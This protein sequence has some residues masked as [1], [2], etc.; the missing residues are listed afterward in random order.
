MVNNMKLNYYE[1]KQF[2]DVIKKMGGFIPIN[3]VTQ[4]HK[5]RDSE[6]I[7]N[8]IF[9]YDTET[10]TLFWYEDL[11]KWDI[12]KYELD[13][14]N[15]KYDSEI[16]KWVYKNVSREKLN[17]L[18]DYSEL[19]AHTIVYLWT[20]S[21][22][23]EKWD[24]SFYGRTNE[25]FKEFI[26]ILQNQLSI[27]EK[28]DVKMI[29]YVHNLGFDFANSLTNIFD[30][31][32]V[33]S[34]KSHS[35]MYA[36]DTS[37]LFE[38]RDSYILTNSS[39]A[40]LTKDNIKYKKQKE[41]DD[42]LKLRLPHTD[43]SS[44]NVLEYAILDTLSLAES[45]YKEL[46]EYK[47]VD[48]IP[49]TST[50][51]L[52][53]A[54]KKEL[55]G[56]SSTNRDRICIPNFEMYMYQLD[57]FCGGDT[58]AN[59]LY[60]GEDLTNIDSYDKRSSYPSVMIYEKYPNAPFIKDYPYMVEKYLNNENYCFLATVTFNKIK[61]KCCIPYIKTYKAYNIKNAHFDN[62]RIFE[63]DELTM[64]LTNID[65]Q[66]I[67]ENYSIKSYVCTELYVTSC[68]YLTYKERKFI[69][70]N[71]ANKTKLKGIE[72]RKEDYSRSKNYINA[73]FG[74]N[75]TK[76]VE[77]H[78][79][80]ANNEWVATPP[81]KEEIIEELEKKRK[82]PQYTMYARGIF[83]T[84]YARKELYSGIN[85]FGN[86][87][88]VY[89]DTDSCKGILTKEIEEKF[90]KLNEEIIEKARR[91]LPEDLFE[92]CQPKDTKGNV[93]FLGTWDKET[94][95]NIYQK[96]KTYGAKKYCYVDND[97]KG[98]PQLHITVSGLSKNASN[99]INYSDFNKKHLFT[100]D[101]SGRTIARYS[102]NQPE[103]N[104]DGYLYN[105]KNSLSLYPTT[106]LLGITNEYENLINSM[107]DVLKENYIDEKGEIIE[108][109]EIL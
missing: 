16:E 5:D 39:L 67:L 26:K 55:S 43:I 69:L 86:F 12:Y 27:Q 75:V 21:I 19:L 7:A 88:H 74:R 14:K 94:E 73:D 47:R 48:K 71:Y 6:Y 102:S 108:N 18:Y 17:G 101:I 1:Y 46:Q 11:K 4:W 97:K 25:E 22:Y 105:D 68:D 70:E 79:E 29:I 41:F 100:S 87:N 40:N 23:N 8:Q 59:I 82:K 34:R 53:Q 99:Y 31:N 51:K 45:L 91:I 80:F 72:E 96:F 32:N 62:G 66:L 64:K 35:P 50:S 30:F 49:L 85:A 103:L 61:S 2:N 3:I 60:S 92:L 15:Y 78:V 52:R 95:N 37:G 38:F 90:N 76:L 24:I 20:F 36:I 109:E 57:I 63:A 54:V 107:H 106:Y 33:F 13:I 104:I 44:D 56:N 9:T 65:L 77:N 83:I 58:H 98:N 89:N 84:A 93:Q 10:T 28:K 81:T 42:Y